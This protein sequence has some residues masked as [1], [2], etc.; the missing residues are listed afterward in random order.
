M[1]SG[2]FF[3]LLDSLSKTELQRFAD[4]VHSP[5]FNKNLDNRRFLNIIL[6]DTQRSLSKEDIFGLLYPE[7]IY[8]A[9]RITDRVYYLSRL[10]EQFLSLNHITQDATIHKIQLLSETL[11]RKLYPIAETVASNL[12]S[13]LQQ[14]RQRDNDYF[15]KTYLFHSERD[16]YFAGREKRQRDESL[17]KR[18]DSL[19]IFYISAKLKDCCEMLNRAQ[20]IK[21]EYRMEMLEKLKELIRNDLSRYAAIPAI[22]AYYYIMLMLQQPEEESHYTTLITL[23]DSSHDIFPLM[24]LRD[25]Y[26]YAQNYCIRKI[27]AGNEQYYQAIFSLNK[28][29][30]SSEIIFNG[31]Y[32]TQWDYK[33]MVSTGLRLKEYEWTLNFINEYKSK[34]PE[35]SRSN[36]YTYNLANYHYESGD[37]K[38]AVKLLRNV[39]FTD[40][41]YNLDAKSMMLKIY[42][43]KDE[44]EA[45][46]ALTASFRI[47]LTRNKLISKQHYI[48]YNNLLK[49]SK[50]AYNLKNKLPYQRGK[51]YIKKVEELRETI[52]CNGN[53]IN[54]RWL[55]A[56]VDQ[57]IKGTFGLN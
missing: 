7:E 26:N 49:Y 19:D 17:Q 44:E 38:K 32:I 1:Y 52:S 27:N 41:Y 14:K 56:Q 13:E 28:K 21:S 31:G 2:R 16:R 53:I 9:R 40:V 11:D 3:L 39:E 30:L 48:M 29:L 5:F 12:E 6:Q 20:I 34:L 24:E 50:K 36:A 51:N 46:R 15:Y 45:F 10:L 57:L 42:F 43:E 23:L 18:T 33:N 4:F 8:D 22:A 54:S 47:Y 25:L 35:D 37:H 55:L